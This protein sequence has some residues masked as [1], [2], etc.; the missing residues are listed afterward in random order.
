MVDISDLNKA[1]QLSG[2]RMSLA[3]GIEVMN[4]P[5]VRVLGFSIGPPRPEG[6]PGGPFGGF[7]IDASNMDH[8]PQMLDTIKQQ[9][10]A[11]LGAIDHELEQLGVTGVEPEQRAASKK[12]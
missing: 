3:R 12:K 11:R 4:Q 6:A 7:P 8:P 10:T 2:E 9:M 1:S 5:N